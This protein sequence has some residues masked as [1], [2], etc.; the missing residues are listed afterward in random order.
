MQRHDFKF[1]P[2][3]MITA[4]Y[5]EPMV[6]RAYQE[7]HNEYDE[8]KDYG[9]VWYQHCVT[10]VLSTLQNDDVAQLLQTGI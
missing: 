1:S 5:S 4:P 10:K 7:N 9:V 8:D 6:S 3:S 2:K